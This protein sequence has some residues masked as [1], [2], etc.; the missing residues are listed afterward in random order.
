VASGGVGYAPTANLRLDLGYAHL[1]IEDAEIENTLESQ[2]PTT[3]HTLRGEYEVEA[4]ILSAQL[5]WGI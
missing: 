3:K 1:F 5:N 4:D 2:V